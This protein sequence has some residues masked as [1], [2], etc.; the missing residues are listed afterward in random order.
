V[1]SRNEVFELSAAPIL[2]SSAEIHEIVASV[3]K[4]RVTV[5]CL[6]PGYCHSELER[7]MNSR[8]VAVAK[9][10]VARTTEVGARTLVDASLRGPSSHGKYL[11]DCKVRDC[12]TIVEGKGGSQLQ[13]RV[14]S[15][16]A[17]EL[18][19]IQPGLTTLISVE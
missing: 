7:D 18:E 14:W 10:I 9:K 19:K 6:N 4:L 3:E 16:L 13:A 17:I 1:R 12:A 2:N 11:S 15:E 8:V 5:N